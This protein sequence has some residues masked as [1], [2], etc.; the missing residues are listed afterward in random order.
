MNELEIIHHSQM[1]GLSV[2]FDT[3]DYRT[4]HVHPEWELILVLQNSLEV[5]CAQDRF[6]LQP[7]QLVLFNPG[8]PH[9]FRKT[10]ESCTFL[11]MQLS[12]SVLPEGVPVHV[13]GNLLHEHLPD[14][15][16]S[17]IRQSL[18]QILDS[19]LHR[20]P[21]F[22]LFCMGKSCLL[23]HELLELL[24]SHILSRE[25]T[26]S[27]DK[28]NARLQ[29]LIRF[30]DEN[31]MNAVRLSDFARAEGCSLSYLSRFIKQTMNQT[32]QDYVTSVRFHCACK[33]MAA[34][35]RRMLDICMESG[36]SDYRYFSREFKRQYGMTPE[37]Y[38]ER[39]HHSP[40]EATMVRRSLH[41]VER[42]YTTEESLTL[43]RQWLLP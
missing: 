15:R 35:N 1:E 10:E 37:A 41:S 43:M 34:G 40:M 42:F 12:S 28:R 17:S 26:S 3:V 2:F 14:D 18:T 6:V 25:E 39:I 20:R 32:F 19:Y 16:L 22:R 38:S 36:F 21:H 5:A 33:L 13:D 27:I 24:P 4:P 23:L 7:G 8:Q 31:Y 9:E 11:C 30:V 29:R